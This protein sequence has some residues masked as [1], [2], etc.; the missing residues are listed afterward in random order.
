[1]S[2]L[3]TLSLADEVRREDVSTDRGT[4]AVLRT[5]PEQTSLPHGCVL[6]VPGWTGS[7]ED[8]GV[9]LP[10]L[11]AAGWYVATYDQRGQYESAAGPG[12]DFTLSGFASDARSVSSAVFGEQ[13]R[14]HI[15]GHS[16]GG[17]VA[18]AAVLE[19]PETWASLTL[20]CSGPGGFSGDE[21]R[22]LLESAD[23]IERD[24]LESVYRTK[25]QRDRDRGIE[26]PP[27]EIEQFMHRRF[28]ANSPLSLA[29]MT[30]LLAEAPDR[31]DELAAVD[32]PKAVMRGADDD[33]WPPEVQDR[34]ADALGTRPI[35]I[36]GAAHSPAVERPESTRDALARIFLR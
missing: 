24:G 18:A 26:P 21:A 13:E 29:A 33:G 12:D 20:M 30:R 10:L 27:P 34:L 22:E 25:V 32:L 16:F 7:K 3:K 9:L 31:T 35:V 36:D 28:L 2:T 15:V 17:L 23:A 6:L 1:M 5:R 8:F 14:P 11:A 19:Q 4:F